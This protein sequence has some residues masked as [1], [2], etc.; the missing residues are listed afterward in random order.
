M[1]LKSVVSRGLILDLHE[2]DADDDPDDLTDAADDADEDAEGGREAKGGDGKDE[3]ALLDTELHGQEADEVGEEG[4]ERHDEDGVEVG[5][6]DAREAASA[7]DTEEQ[8]H[9]QHLAR[10]DDTRQVFED[11]RAIEGSLV[12]CV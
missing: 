5:E 2:Q 8:E 7:V 3:T 1:P 6:G 12:F 9:E 4:G 11:K 10:L